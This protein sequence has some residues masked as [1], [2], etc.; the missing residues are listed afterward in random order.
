MN[1]EAW[2]AV[3]H[4]ITKSRTQVSDWTEL[5]KWEDSKEISFYTHK[6]VKSR[7]PDNTKCWEEGETM[8]LLYNTSLIYYI[9][10]KYFGKW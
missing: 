9:L 1:K 2:R 6:I 3:V 10:V 8:N 7:K 4:G 5:K